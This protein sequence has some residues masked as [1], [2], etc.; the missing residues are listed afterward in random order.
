MSENADVFERIQEYRDQFRLL[1]LSAV[2]DGLVEVS[3]AVSSGN[4]IGSESI[5]KLVENER[6]P[7]SGQ[8]TCFCSLR[9]MS[10]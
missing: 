4:Y 7:W 8:A 10:L 2:R 1:M 5:P 3:K 9:L 6:L